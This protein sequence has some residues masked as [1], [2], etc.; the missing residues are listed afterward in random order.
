MEESRFQR[1]ED[2]VDDVK[3]DL[4]ELKIDIKVHMATIEHHISQDQKIINIIA[5]VMEKL[6]DM[7]QM[8]EDYRFDKELKERKMQ[9][10]KTWTVKLGLASTVIGIVITLAKVFG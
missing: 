7:V 2:K 6:P 4:A 8:I 10:I 1:L 3:Q 5:P 9:S